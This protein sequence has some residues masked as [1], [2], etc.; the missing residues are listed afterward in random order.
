MAKG[1]RF[2]TRV[3][4]KQI[5]W[6]DGADTSA[7]ITRRLSSAVIES[8]PRRCWV[9]CVLSYKGGK[10][11]DINSSE[12]WSINDLCY[13]KIFLRLRSAFLVCLLVF[14][15]FRDFGLDVI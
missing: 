8:D 9:G 6:G 12:L 5:R 11:A 10:G 13:E 2:E 4:A 1:G 3:G 14:C 15:C 7:S